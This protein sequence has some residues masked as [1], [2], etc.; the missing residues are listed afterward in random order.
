MLSWGIKTWGELGYGEWGDEA[1][2]TPL[3][4]LNKSWRS[5]VIPQS[6]TNLLNISFENSGADLRVG[7]DST[8]EFFLGHKLP[9]MFDEI[10]KNGKR[11]GAKSNTD[12]VSPQAGISWVEA[13]GRKD[14]MSVWGH[15]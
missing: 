2:A 10:P 6:F 12:T 7:P 15:W 3:D 5:R 1:I 9:G 14:V 8:E 13:K 4:G 11:G